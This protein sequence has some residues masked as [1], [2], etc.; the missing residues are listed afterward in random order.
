MKCNPNVENFNLRENSG[1]KVFVE[2]NL[3]VEMFLLCCFSR[4]HKMYMCIYVKL[5]V[6]VV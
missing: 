6:S 3:V 2:Q 1:N 5:S 4:K